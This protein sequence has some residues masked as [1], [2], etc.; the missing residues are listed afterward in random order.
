MLLTCAI[1]SLFHI[2]G[3]HLD[4]GCIMCVLSETILN[5]D[6]HPLLHLQQLIFGEAELVKCLL[7]LP[8]L[9]RQPI[10][11]GCYHGGTFAAATFREQE[12]DV[13][14]GHQPA[15]CLVQTTGIPVAG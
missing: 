2:S 13:R 6:S 4:S 9:I 10:R 15:D 5:L 11:P 8:R 14:V 7:N 3:K 1:R 12:T